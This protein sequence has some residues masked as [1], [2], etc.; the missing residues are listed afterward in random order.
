M[1]GL[2]TAT[3]WRFVRFGLLVTGK[4]EESFLPILFRSLMQ[5]GQCT[6]EVIR[7]ISQ[8]S[9]IASKQRRTELKLAGKKIPA[10]DE[11]IGLA[12]RAFLQRHKDAYVLLIDDLEGDRA[13]QVKAVYDRYRSL[14]DTMLGSLK[15]RAAVHFLVN[16]LEA[17][18]FAD[19]QALN[20][21]LG[22]ALVDHEADVEQ[23]RHPKN[24]LKQLFQGFD[25]IKHGRRIIERLDVRHILSRPD[26]CASLRTLFGWCAKA[27]GLPLSDEY[28]LV[29]G[30]YHP[31]TGVQI[32]QNP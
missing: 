2:E 6:F 32:P 18:Y 28:R 31:I 7:R 5:P 20:E 17:Y 24:H 23:L 11:E 3:G 10:K 1:S 13:A 26:T 14:L 29:D 22:T 15:D 30:Q 9:P 19:A 8:L 27:L 21:I 16:M 4:G 25:E 12:A